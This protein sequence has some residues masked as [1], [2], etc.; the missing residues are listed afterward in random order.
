MGDTEFL[1]YVVRDLPSVR[2]V[3]TSLD[4]IDFQTLETNFIIETRA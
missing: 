1:E 3:D 4:D 2:I